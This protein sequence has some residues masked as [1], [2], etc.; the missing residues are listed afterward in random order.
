MNILI[1]KPINSD[2][3]IFKSSLTN[4]KIVPIIHIDKINF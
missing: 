3:N 1:L 2:Y 4:T